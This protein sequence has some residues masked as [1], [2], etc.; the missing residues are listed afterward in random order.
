MLYEDLKKYGFEY[1][2]KRRLNQDNL[3][4]VFDVIRRQGGSCSEPT[5]M[6][7]A[8][9]SQSCFY[10]T[11]SEVHRMQTARWIFVI[12]C[13]KSKIARNLTSAPIYHLKNTVYYV[14]DAKQ[15]IA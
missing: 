1:L 11:C 7:F 12:Y 13:P 5:P 9:L 2:L 3:E 4:K 14:W 8:E 15:I 10:E 6:H